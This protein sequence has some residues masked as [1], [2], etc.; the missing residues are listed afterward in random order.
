MNEHSAQNC[1]T[2][3]HIFWMKFIKAII[4]ASIVLLFSSSCTLKHWADVNDN[5]TAT[6]NATLWP[7]EKSDLSPDPDLYFGRLENG[8]R[9]ILVKN[10]TPADRVSL[11]LYVHAG[12]LNETDDERGIA[13]FLEHLQFDGSNHFQP[14]ELVKYFQRIGMQFGPDANAHTGFTDTV[15]DILLPRG[16]R[17]SMTEAM[18]VLN[19]Y[20]QGALLLPSQIEKEKNIVLAEKRSRDSSSYRVIQSVFKFELPG[21]LPPKR[22]PIGQTETIRRFDK[23]MVKYFYDTWYRP[24][25]MVLIAVGQFDPEEAQELVENQFSRLRPRAKE[26]ESPSFGSFNHQGIKPFYYYEKNIGTTTVR[27][28]TINQETQP[29]DSSKF[30]YRELAE[31]LANRIL[32]E[33]LAK[34]VQKPNAPITESGSGSGFFLQHIKYAEISA[35]CEP[36]KWEEALYLIEQTLRRVL[37]Y[38]FTVEELER[39]KK[40]KKAELSHAQGTEMT[41]DSNE[42]AMTL[43][44]DLRNA[45]VTLSAKQEMDLLLPMLDKLT[46]ENINQQF[47]KIWASDHRLI[48]VTGSANLSEAGTS[49]EDLILKTYFQSNKLEVFPP[50]QEK[51]SVFPYLPVPEISEPIIRSQ[52]LDD[53]GIE[54]VWFENGVFLSTKQTDFKKDEAIVSLVFGNGK[55][56]EPTD[57][58]GLAY[59]AEA[60]LNEAGFGM[61]NRTELDNALSGRIAEIELDIREDIFLIRGKA[62]SNELPLLFQ[63]LRTFLLDPGFRQETLEL[64]RKRL[65]QRLRT[66]HHEV[67]G[68]MQI[69]GIRF[70]SGGD[71]RLSLATP[72]QLE[73]LTLDDIRTWFQVQLN[74]TQ[75]ELAA[76]GDIDPK[77]VKALTAKYM[78][79][80]PLSPANTITAHGGPHLRFPTG[81]SLI[82]EADS[83]IQNSLVVVAYPTVDMWDIEQTRRL[84]LLSEVFSEQ[85]RV[86]VREKLGAAYSP[87]AYNR[88]YRAYPGFGIFFVFVEASPDEVDIV[89]DAVRQIAAGLQTQDISLDEFH[90]ALDPTLTRIKD[91]RQSNTYWLNSVMTGSG[92]YPQQIQW[93]RTIEDDYAAITKDEIRSFAERYLDNKAAAIIIIHPSTF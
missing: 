14:D 85:L 52:K 20:A 62:S 59:L 55:A 82:L 66:A 79:A 81:E 57:K 8:F 39:A 22:F 38:G 84:A 17:Q 1:N 5:E 90:R 18:Y 40:E 9:Y 24:E 13:H 75:I 83:Q 58:P 89:V 60:M 32:N 49:A 34:Q 68:I 73:R 36:Q 42:L 65:I 19:E 86:R 78:T 15:F 25:S 16:D 3:N 30:R 93:A 88:P 87:Y 29:I 10:N 70:L 77:Q 28:E 43:M 47:K 71:S 54:Q 61:M 37:K 92:R 46:V 72:E 67:Q 2:F 76:V 41:E 64:V 27:I 31:E 53:L 23:P 21:A 69:E 63:L 6:I 12:S 91:L 26:A 35:Q 44:G 74:E 11:H 7:H 4:F 51:A 56:S 48:L 80:L 45:R 33:Q 50:V